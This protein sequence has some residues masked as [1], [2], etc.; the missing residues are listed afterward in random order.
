MP[1]KTRPVE[2]QTF[3]DLGELEKYFEREEKVITFVPVRNYIEQN[4]IFMDDEFYGR[5]TNWLCF[6]EEGLTAFCN[7]IGLPRRIISDIRKEQLASDVLNDYLSNNELRQKLCGYRFVVNS[8]EKAVLGIVTNKYQEYSNQS[9]L[10]DIKRKFPKLFRQF[11]VH[12]SYVINTN[13]Y[14]RFLS[15][16]IKAGRITGRG[17]TGED[18]CQIG[19]QLCNSMVG[20]SSVK[21][22]YFIY[23]LICANGLIVETAQTTASVR[24]IGDPETFSIR[25]EKTI[26]PALRGIN[27]VEKMIISLIEMPFD[28]EKIAELNGAELVYSIIPISEQE[29]EKRK[30]LKKQDR[31]VFD[32]NQLSL[33]PEKYAGPLSSKIFESVYRSNYSMFDFINVFT[34]YA[35]L[36]DR[37]IERKIEIEKKTGDFVS[38]VLDNKKRLG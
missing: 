7:T 23:C 29:R 1:F 17:G 35:H 13:L 14:L 34:E 21:V 32:I 4:S 36:G 37:S 28:P 10:R 38:W 26:P 18:A 15:E 27:S 19:L 6:N 2:I 30:K 22:S 16:R 11:S 25:L 20:D 3:N 24:H 31:I 8:D 33:Y 9:L 12:E 5:G